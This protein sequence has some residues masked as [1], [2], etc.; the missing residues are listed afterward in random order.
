MSKLQA[1]ESDWELECWSVV[2]S[3]GFPHCQWRSDGNKDMFPRE[4]ETAPG[5]LEVIKARLA[6]A[7]SNLG[8]W[9]VFMPMAE[10]L[11]SSFQPKHFCDSVTERV[12]NMG[13]LS[14]LWADTKHPSGL[15]SEEI[16]EGHVTGQVQLKQ[17]VC[18][19]AMFQSQPTW[20]KWVELSEDIL[21][22]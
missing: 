20:I 3:E 18:L 2:L 21:N 16:L 15:N 14:Y 17:W 8:Q 13:S 10:C 9:K 7:W 5:S 11:K 4:A 19:Y 1:K 22:F 6:R 12:S